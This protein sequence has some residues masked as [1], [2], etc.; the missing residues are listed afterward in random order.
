MTFS[1]LSSLS[2]NHVSPTSEL[3]AFSLKPYCLTQYVSLYNLFCDQVS[4]WQ[5]F[6][7]FGLRPPDHLCP[8]DLKEGT[9]VKLKYC[10]GNFEVLVALLHLKSYGHFIQK[11]K[12]K[13]A[14]TT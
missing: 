10:E 1:P 4:I 9:L 14:P 6:C 12:I 5:V 13:F 3:N 7:Q 2:W 8:G 11:C